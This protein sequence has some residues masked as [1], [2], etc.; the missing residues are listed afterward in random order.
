MICNDFG[1]IS[2]WERITIDARLKREIT[3]QVLTPFIL[4]PTVD[5]GI[6]AGVFL[7][8]VPG[9]GKTYLCQAIAKSAGVNFFNPSAS[10]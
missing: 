10:H 2:D 9:C 1:H 8:G 3:K 6:A 7:H 5:L 4:P